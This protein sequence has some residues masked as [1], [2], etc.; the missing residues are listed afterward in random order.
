MRPVS[1]YGAP[2]SDKK[3]HPTEDDDYFMRAA[4][5]R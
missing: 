3:Q 2:M 5:T 4:E 1:R